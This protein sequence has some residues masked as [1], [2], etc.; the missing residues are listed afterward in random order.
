MSKPGYC[1][2]QTAIP[3]PSSNCGFAGKDRL[4]RGTSAG[5]CGAGVRTTVGDVDLW[6][7]SF[8]AH[9]IIVTSAAVNVR[10]AIAHARD[11]QTLHSFKAPILKQE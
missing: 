9:P 1:P 3:L 5:G 8:R 6:P 4:D 2:A 10:V 7:R 11:G